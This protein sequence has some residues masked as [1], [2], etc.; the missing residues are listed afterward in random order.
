MEF[1]LK[2][3]GWGFAL[4]ALYLIIRN[5][6]QVNTIMQS[7]AKGSSTVFRTLQGERVAGV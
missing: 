4:V 1:L 5:G 7:F 2:F 6:S 3:F